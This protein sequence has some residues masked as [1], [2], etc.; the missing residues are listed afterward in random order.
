MAESKEITLEEWKHRPVVER[1][2][3]VLGWIL[4]RQQ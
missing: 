2:H 3:E 4:E 1:A